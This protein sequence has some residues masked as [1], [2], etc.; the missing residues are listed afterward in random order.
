M[1]YYVHLGRRILARLEEKSEAFEA[2]ETL[3][4]EYPGAQVHSIEEF[5]RTAPAYTMQTDTLNMII[6]GKHGK[7]HGSIR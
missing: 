5:Y 3:K 6:G 4:K 1:C 2:L 7:K